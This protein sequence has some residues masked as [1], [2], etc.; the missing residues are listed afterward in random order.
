MTTMPVRALLMIALPLLMAA[1]DKSAGGISA[2]EFTSGALSYLVSKRCEKPVRS[3]APSIEWP[4]LTYGPGRPPA[5]G[6]K[7]AGPCRGLDTWV[8]QESLAAGAYWGQNDHAAIE[9]DPNTTLFDDEKIHVAFKKAFGWALPERGDYVPPPNVFLRFD[10]KKL[11]ALFDRIYVKPTDKIAESTGQEVY[12]VFFKETITR[13]AREVALIKGGLPKAELTKQAK[14]YQA[15]AKAAGAKF[16]GP[17]YLRQAAA[18]G[19]PKDAD[20]GGERAYRTFGIIL[21]RTADG[22][23]PAIDRLL[24]RVIKD[25]DPT[26]AQEIGKNL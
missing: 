20:Q 11:S 4:A 26:L 19:V 8:L 1:S 3:E 5:W 9:A 24:Q 21:R 16:Q 18:T 12:D 13:F 23:W 17:A 7:A 22:S 25:Y 14:A 6:R 10:G 15:A 2:P